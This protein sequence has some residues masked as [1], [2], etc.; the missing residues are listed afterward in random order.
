MKVLV[1]AYPFLTEIGSCDDIAF[2]VNPWGNRE[3]TSKEMT[4]ELI[5]GSYDGLIVGTKKVDNE[6]TDRCQSLRV[7]SRLGVGINN[8]D[9][10]HFNKYGVVTTYTPFGP[11]DST[12][13]MA[14]SLI[15]A[16][17]RKLSVYDKKIRQGVWERHFDMRLM[18]AT[19][20]IVG[21]GRIGK[22]VAS[23]LSG[24]GC[25]ILLH[26]IDPDHATANAMKLGFVSKREL[27]ETC[28]VITLHIP[29][30]NDT[31]GWLSSNELKLMKQKV[32]LVNT[33]RGG[34]VNEQDIFDYL[35]QHKDSF[36]CVDVF[37]EEPY[38]GKLKELE[39]VLLT[40]HSSTFTVG[41]RKQ[42]ELAAIENCLKVLR[43]QFCENVVSDSDL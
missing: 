26:D 34:I 42:T 22:R 3:F 25:R 5:R 8:I 36:F 13:E 6:L 35:V 10:I 43:G 24:F 19:V 23:I 14:V 28:D 7:I 41:S 1:A 11:T 40:P 9:V 18:D 20:G 31:Y 21:F 15:L 33:A 39:N 37:E 12:A 2:V 29:L 38:H 27:L 17:M 32:T 16:G 30:K 4:E